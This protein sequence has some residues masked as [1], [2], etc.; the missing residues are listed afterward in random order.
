MTFVRFAIQ[1]E[2]SFVVEL[3][4]RNSNEG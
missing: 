3:V 2:M 4:Q 1:Y